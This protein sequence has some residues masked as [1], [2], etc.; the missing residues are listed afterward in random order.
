VQFHNEPDR[1][2]SV[3]ASL[4]YVVE[5]WT[6]SEEDLPSNVLLNHALERLDMTL[7]DLERVTIGELRP[8]FCHA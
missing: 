6:A 3:L 1:C 4:L 2:D 8:N 5:F 7:D